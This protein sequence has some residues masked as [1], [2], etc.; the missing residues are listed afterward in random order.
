MAACTDQVRQVLELKRVPDHTTLART[1][2]KPSLAQWEPLNDALLRHLGVQERIGAADS[3]GFRHHPASAYYQ[4]R[5]GRKGRWWHKGGFV[6]GTTS[7]LIG[8]GAW[9][10]VRVRTRSGWLRCVPK[11]V[12]LWC[13]RGV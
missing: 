2:A 10:G 13:A 9:G 3:T 12:G 1:F 8:G 11:R 4:S 5:C 6:V 7:Q